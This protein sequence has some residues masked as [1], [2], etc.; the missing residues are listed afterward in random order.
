VTTRPTAWRRLNSQLKGE[1]IVAH[2]LIAGGGTV[3]PGC[4][5]LL[6]TPNAGSID[7][8]LVIA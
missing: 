7:G 4:A 8:N 2:N 5:P 3:R 1:R 6:V